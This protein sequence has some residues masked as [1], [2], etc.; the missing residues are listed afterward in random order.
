MRAAWFKGTWLVAALLRD[1]G[2]RVAP[3]IGPALDSAKGR[4]A[5]SSCT[6]LINASAI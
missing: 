4:L 1:A 5:S 6:V 3:I 2:L